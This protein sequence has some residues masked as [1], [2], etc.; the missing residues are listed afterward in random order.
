MSFLAPF[1][2][3]GAI[4]GSIP[5]ILHFFY[6]AR[7]RPVPWGA[8]KFL[9]LAIEQ[10]SRRL[11]FQE[12]ILLLLRILVLVLLAFALARPASLAISGK[13]GR[14]ESVDA[15]IVIDTSYSMAA[16]EGGKTRFQRAKEGALSILEELP[17][18]STVQIISCSDRAKYLGPTNPSNLD[19]RSLAAIPTFGG[20]LSNARAARIAPH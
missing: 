5:V 10:T 17:Q 3:F 11:R 12:W 15:I 4:A 19:R 20:H 9:R 14:G 16:R 2:L 8:M 18:N 1:M 6:R 7:Y 13:G